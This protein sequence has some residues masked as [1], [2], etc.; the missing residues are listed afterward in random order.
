MVVEDIY[1]LHVYVVYL[2]GNACLI[3]W[4]ACCINSFFGYN[5][6]INSS[7]CSLSRAMGEIPHHSANHKLFDLSKYRNKDIHYEALMWYLVHIKR[8]TK[9]CI[10]R[11]NRFINS[12]VGV[13][14]KKLLQQIVSVSRALPVSFKSNNIKFSLHL[15]Q[16][17]KS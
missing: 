13:V 17:K 7:S 10:C 4:A 6:M 8:T 14:L 1:F 9:G 15:E 5:R 11:K 2:K 16:L 12:N 3:S